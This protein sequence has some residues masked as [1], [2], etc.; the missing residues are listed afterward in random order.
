MDRRA[1]PLEVGWRPDHQPADVSGETLRDHVLRH[2]AT[3]PDARVEAPFDYVDHPVVDREFDLDVGVAVEERRHNRSDE[4]LGRLGRHA[5]SHATHR[6]V[7]EA[8]EHIQ[9][10][11]DLVEGASKRRLQRFAGG[12]ERHAAACPIEKANP[13]A[14]L[15]TPDRVT[16]GRCTDAK[17][18]RSATEVP[19][20]RDL[21]EIREVGEIG[22]TKL[23]VQRL[24]RKCA[25]RR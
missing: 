3:I 17:L 6:R 10:A 18:E 25:G 14:L 13:Q 22:P 5:H 21:Q 2:R 19:V 11:A 16:Q 1:E 23:H 7:A 15:Q 8:I 4:E 20:L 24:P 12:G 9:G